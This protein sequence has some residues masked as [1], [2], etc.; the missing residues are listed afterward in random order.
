MYI[1]NDVHG[2]PRSSVNIL[3]SGPPKESGD[4]CYSDLHDLCFPLQPSLA[5]SLP[6]LPAFEKE[7]KLRGLA[8][9]REK[10]VPQASSGDANSTTMP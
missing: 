6:Q 9:Q 10:M 5:K 4:Q 3:Q 8:R 7:A 1:G 2:S